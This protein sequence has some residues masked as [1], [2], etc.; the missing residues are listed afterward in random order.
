MKYTLNAPYGV[1]AIQLDN[2]D[3]ALYLHGECL[4]LA[5][6]HL[7]DDSVIATG[8]RMAEVLGVPF[9][10]LTLPEPENEEWCWNEVV[11]ALGWGKSMKLAVWLCVR[12]WSA[13][14]RISLLMTTR[15]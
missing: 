11:E 12:F 3:E 7:R 13:V 8:E 9:T 4:A 5:D 2:G 6:F 1:T 15:C 10:F 14:S